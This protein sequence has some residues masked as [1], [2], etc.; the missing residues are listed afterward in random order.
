M[1][2]KILGIAIFIALVFALGI[3]L[4]NKIKKDIGNIDFK[5]IIVNN[6][7][8]GKTVPPSLTNYGE[9][10]E[11]AV[12]KRVIDGDTI[13]LDDGRKVRYIGI[14]SPEMTDK[15][16]EVLCLAKLAKEE[17]EKIVLGKTVEMEKDISDKDK[18]DRLLRYIWIDGKMVNLELIKNGYAAVATY[19]PDIKYKNL[20]VEGFNLKKN[21]KGNCATNN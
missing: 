8:I 10:K 4:E 21:I 18:Y 15:R 11:L 19:P 3:F 17:N 1:I 5:K 12:V 20:F 16:P 6:V 7:D 9:A 14:N 13:E 2:K